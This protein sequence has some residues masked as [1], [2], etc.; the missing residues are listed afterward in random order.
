MAQAPPRGLWADHSTPRRAG[1]GL[2]RLGTE[3]GLSKLR[4]EAAG[5]APSRRG[6]RLGGGEPQ[7]PTTWGKVLTLPLWEGYLGVRASQRLGEVLPSATRGSRNGQAGCGG[8]SAWARKPRASSPV[9]VVITRL[10]WGAPGVSHSLHPAPQPR[11]QRSPTDLL[12]Y[13][14]HNH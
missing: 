12:S 5:A 10:L 9:V 3:R 13:S 11:W 7:G 14:L 2:A 6:S 8:A 1:L 4:R